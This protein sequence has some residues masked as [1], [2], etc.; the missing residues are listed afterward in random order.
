[1]PYFNDVYAR[2]PVL[3]NS[4]G[5]FRY[6]NRIRLQDF[7]E[8]AVISN[9]IYLIPDS[10][11]RGA[12][13]AEDVDVAETAVLLRTSNYLHQSDDQQQSTFST[14][15]LMALTG[16]GTGF[17][18][19]SVNTIHNIAGNFWILGTNNLG[20]AFVHSKANG[21]IL[22]VGSNWVAYDGDFTSLP[23]S[24]ASFLRRDDDNN[25]Y[26]LVRQT[27]SPFAIGVFK[28][29]SGATEFLGITSS[30]ITS[31]ATITAYNISNDGLVHMMAYGNSEA[32]SLDGGVT[33]T[34]TSSGLDGVNDIAY[35]DQY[36]TWLM[37]AVTGASN[38]GCRISL[39]SGGSW[40]DARVRGSTAGDTSLTRFSH[41]ERIDP[42]GRY[43]LAIRGTNPIRTYVSEDGGK[44]WTFM[45]ALSVPN[46]GNPAE[47]ASTI[48]VNTGSKILLY[49][50]VRNGGF[51]AWNYDNAMYTSG[52]IGFALTTV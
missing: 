37:T 40:A 20:G 46:Y 26:C 11:G 21:N 12:S 51:P 45:Q 4:I 49:M 30:G 16:L 47:F 22:N 6:S 17:T 36:N 28:K 9:P 42:E 13:Y 33:W 43:L 19:T 38:P 2:H 7:E 10:A 48:L 27:G 24:T 1:M 29:L 32:R 25:L 3:I 50:G 35:S 39:N 5:N 23:A 41:I 31:S 14:D 15:K 8:A 44:T 34:T 18:C 52:I